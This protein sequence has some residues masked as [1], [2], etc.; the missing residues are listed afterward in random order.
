[1]AVDLR[2]ESI[3][4]QYN[5]EQFEDYMKENGPFMIVYLPLYSCFTQAET[6][7]LCYLINRRRALCKN[8]EFKRNGGW[9][10]CK[11][12]DICGHL[13]INKTTQTNLISKLVEKK[14]IEIKY[15]RNPKQRFIR[16]LHE[17]IGRQVEKN[18]SKKRKQLD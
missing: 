6:S 13:Q 17:S 16:I 7:M 5:A 4:D 3:D 10:Y 9:F 1:M 15:A 11:M 8:T 14:A 12:V 18:K 2:K